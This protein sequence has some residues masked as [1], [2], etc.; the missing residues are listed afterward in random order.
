MTKYTQEE[1]LV[2]LAEARQEVHDL[3]AAKAQEVKSDLSPMH[4]VKE[5][6]TWL[7]DGDFK[8][9]TVSY[10]GNEGL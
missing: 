5:G 8:V 4:D 3:Y 10:T 6:Q 9:L 7:W 1:V 2:L